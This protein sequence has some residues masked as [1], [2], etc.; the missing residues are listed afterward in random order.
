MAKKV[1]R[2]S[3]LHDFR[4]ADGEIINYAVLI[5]AT[6]LS[7]GAL[8]NRLRCYDVP[9]TDLQ[10]FLKAAL[11]F[12]TQ[13]AFEA[14]VSGAE[15]VSEIEEQKE[16]K[17]TKA[18]LDELELRIKKEKLREIV[19]KNEKDEGKYVLLSDVQLS[20]DNFLIALRMNLEALPEQV[21]QSV[22]VCRDEHEAIEIILEALRHLTRGWTENPIRIGQDE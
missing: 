18:Q 6:G 1:G 2:R 3:R 12:R 8:Q 20:L 9:P 21:A 14:A 10:S 22:M 17:S 11:E 5:A 16:T 15:Y 19:F 4:D 13:R 7:Q